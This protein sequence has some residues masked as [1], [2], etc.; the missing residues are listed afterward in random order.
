MPRAKWLEELEEEESLE[1][2][3]RFEERNIEKCYETVVGQYFLKDYS[4]II[5]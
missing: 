2:L 5:T 4:I 3:V 1:V